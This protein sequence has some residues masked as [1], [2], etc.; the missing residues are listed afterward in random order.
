MGAGSPGAQPAYRR[1]AAY[2]SQQP[3]ADHR[4]VVLGGP[5]GGAKAGELRDAEAA[6]IA[7]V[8]GDI[9]DR[10]G[11]WPVYD[12]ADEA[13]RPARL[14]DV[15]ILIPTRAVLAHL[16]RTL[17]DAEIPYRADT[18]S[19]VYDTQEVRE[20]L[21]VLRAVDDPTDQ[22]A[23]VAAL[24]SPLF[25]CGDDDLFDYRAAGGRWDLQAAPPSQ[26]PLDHPVVAGLTYLGELHRQRWWSEPSA[27]LDRIIRERGAMQLAFAHRRPRDIWRR[28]RF[29]VDQARMY[30]ESQS[31]G[32]REYLAWA[33]LQRREG[34]RVHEP[35]LAE[36]DDDAV[37]IMTIHGAKG[38]EFPIVVVAGTS[39][40]A[41]GRRPGIQVTWPD[42]DLPEIKLNA[43]TT[44]AQFRR[45][46]DLEQE[47][48]DHEKL[49][50][51]TWR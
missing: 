33:E 14:D 34:A 8:L 36:S 16:E 32:L 11:H 47:M 43:T 1:L 25:A 42:G 39:T 9:R 26:L 44:T 31:G 17:D 38:L 29:V 48:D 15:A 27:L 30:G 28:L 13:W 40:T 18:G 2:R 35:L 24:R 20:L 5:D 10:P 12:T 37:R 51:C 6:D 23:L 3:E 19:L 7:A 4:V 22:I 46:Q 50:S 41:G 49:R 45:S 21:S